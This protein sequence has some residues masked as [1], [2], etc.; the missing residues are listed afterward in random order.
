MNHDRRYMALA[1][2]LAARA[3]GRTRPNPVV[4]CVIV[5]DEEIVG[6]GY[7]PYAGAAHAEVFA[8]QEAGERAEGSTVYVNLEPCAHHGRT[9][10]CADALIR[11][12]VR[13]VVV[14]MIDPNFQVAGRGVER[15]RNAG[16]EVTVGVRAEEAREL[17][18]PFVIWIEQERP[19]ITL[20]LAASL[21]GKTATRTG[22][23]QWI[24]G[25]AARARVQRMRDQHDAVL[26]GIGTILA[27]DP[28]LNCRMPGGRDPV[29]I[30][31]D[32]RLRIPEQARVFDSSVESPLWIA[33]GRGANFARAEA[34]GAR[35][36]VR[37]I[38]CRETADGRVNLNDLMVRLGE[39]DLTSVLCEAGG[40]LTGALLEAGL[41]D[42]L[43]LFL[44]PKLIGGHDSRGLLENIGIGSLADAQRL[45]NMRVTQVG[46]DLL[47]E[48][49]FEAS[50][51]LL[52]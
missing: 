19:M 33:T 12:R 40:V 21:D 31:V 27:D 34:L 43:A 28:R 14:A 32:S 18:R 2:R 5:R 50:R 52:A 48:G 38:P 49:D 1:L 22:E 16:I 11:A 36:N 46:E 17:N 8:L 7:H 41:A 30:V 25:P 23:S 29:R 47:I 45:V 3:T 15:L 6:Q 9:P 35:P 44:A 24:T 42:R 4:G 10:P 37:V 51:C 39:M 13:R 26:V 20:K